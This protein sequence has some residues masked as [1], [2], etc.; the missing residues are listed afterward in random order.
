MNDVVT[1]SIAQNIWKTENIE[2][3]LYSTFARHTKPLMSH[4]LFAREDMH[5]TRNSGALFFPKNVGERRGG[6]G[7]NFSGHQKKGQKNFSGWK[8]SFKMLFSD[9]FRLKL[10][11]GQ[12]LFLG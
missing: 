9:K 4:A 8:L 7:K 6:E 10:N 3:L 5:K 12:T 1:Y 2:N 11:M